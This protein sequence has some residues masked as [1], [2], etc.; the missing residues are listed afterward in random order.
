ML[1]VY[2][3]NEIFKKNICHEPKWMF[4]TFKRNNTFCLFPFLLSSDSI[5]FIKICLSSNKEY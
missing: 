3:I 2:H 4:G 1:V 5:D